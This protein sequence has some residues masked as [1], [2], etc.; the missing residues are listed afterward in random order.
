MKTWRWNGSAAAM[1][2]ALESEELSTGTSRKPISG[3]PSDCA[4]FG[5]DLVDVLAHCRVL[6]HEPVADAVVPDRRQFDA[7]LRHLLAEEAVGNLH[8]H[9]GAVAHQRIGADGAAMGEVLEHG[10]TVLDDLVRLHALHLGDEADA[11][12]IVLVARIV[13]A[14]GFRQAGNL[15]RSARLTDAPF[16]WAGTICSVTDGVKSVIT[17][18]SVPCPRQ[19]GF[20]SCG[21]AARIAGEAFTIR[22][23]GSQCADK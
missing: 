3:R 22:Q 2:G 7:L 10:Q 23:T 9:A 11:A 21:A 12:G 8:Q 4:D 14:L 15:R 16:V 19:G 18:S 20:A 17:M 13:E 5:D 1:S 6:R